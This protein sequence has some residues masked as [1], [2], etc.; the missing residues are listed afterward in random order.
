MPPGA[1]IVIVGSVAGLTGHY[2]VAYT[3]S[4]WALR[5]LAKAACLELGRAASASTSCTPATSRPR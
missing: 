3:A 4:K 5:G 2:P 1:S